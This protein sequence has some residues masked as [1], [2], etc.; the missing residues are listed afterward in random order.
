MLL[1]ILWH[2]IPK[3]CIQYALVHETIKFSRPE[4]YMDVLVFFSVS[5]CKYLGTIICEMLLIY[6]YT[7]IFLFN[8]VYDAVT[9]MK[10]NKLSTITT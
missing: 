8:F 4:L 9:V 6:Y 5:E 1:T 10:T 3:N 7:S 2:I